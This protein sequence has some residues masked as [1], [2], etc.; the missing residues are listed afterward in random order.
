MGDYD[1]GG[2][3]GVDGTKHLGEGRVQKCAESFI[4]SVSYSQVG[5]EE[6]L[7]ETAMCNGISGDFYNDFKVQVDILGIL[8][9]M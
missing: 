5:S 7:I 9:K 2:G 6:P 8:F 4:W 3:V 1:A